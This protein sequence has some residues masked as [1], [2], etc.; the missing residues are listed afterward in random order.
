MGQPVARAEA[1]DA[2][3]LE[4]TSNDAFHA[5]VVGKARHAGAQ[6]ADAAHD[7][8]NL[9]AGLACLVES[10]DDAGVDEGIEL[11][12]DVGRPARLGMGDFIV[13]M[14][15]QRGFR[16]IGESESFSRSSGWA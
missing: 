4:E 6:A 8:I 14:L 2:G 7:K 10:V 3:V 5:D 1:N 9:N 13:D 15:Q 11:A 12:P 16:L